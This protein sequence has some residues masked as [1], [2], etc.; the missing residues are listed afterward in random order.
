MRRINPVPG[1]AIAEQDDSGIS[2]VLVCRCGRSFIG[3]GPSRMREVRWQHAQH[4]YSVSLY[5]EGHGFRSV[6]VPEDYDAPGGG[7]R[8]SRKREAHFEDVVAWYAE[9][10]GT[11]TFSSIGRRI[12]IAA[13][14]VKAWL[15]DAGEISP[16]NS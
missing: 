12:G 6:P 8:R 3:A 7:V 2:S 9:G 10:N 13:S 14:T 16:D 4:A 5:G 11:E 1:H 15:I